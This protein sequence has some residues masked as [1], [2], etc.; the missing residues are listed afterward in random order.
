M[1]ARC[2]TR[3]YLALQSLALQRERK[4]SRQAGTFWFDANSKGQEFGDLPKRVI[5]RN[6]LACPLWRAR[7]M[8]VALGGHH[9]WDDVATAACATATSSHA[10]ASLRGRARP[11]RSCRHERD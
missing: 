2:S 8:G 11:L 6:G 4:N 5:L 10:V 9:P 1:A 3:P 7:Q